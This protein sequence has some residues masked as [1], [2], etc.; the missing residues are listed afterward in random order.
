MSRWSPA[1][2][3]L[4]L[5]ELLVRQLRRL[6]RADRAQCPNAAFPPGPTPAL[7][8]TLAHPQIPRDHRRPLAPSKP[9]ASPQPNLLTLHL[10]LRGQAPSLRIPHTTGIAQGSRTVTTRRHPEKVSNRSSQTAGNHSSTP[11]SRPLPTNIVR[12]GEWITIDYL[13]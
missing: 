1:E 2:L 9:H 5:R 3:H 8:R 11:A 10:P 12:P 13:R 7:H 4:Q 6:R